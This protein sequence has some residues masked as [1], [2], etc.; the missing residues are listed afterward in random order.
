MGKD[1]QLHHLGLYCVE[2]FANGK[3]DKKARGS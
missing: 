3:M 1:I 2:F